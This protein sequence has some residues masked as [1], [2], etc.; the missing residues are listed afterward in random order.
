MFRNFITGINY[1]KLISMQAKQESFAPHAINRKA[2]LKIEN[3]KVTAKVN[4][5]RSLEPARESKHKKKPKVKVLRREN[6]EELL[7]SIGGESK[8]V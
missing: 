2:Q 8:N 7:Y 4:A 6:K 3:K 5:S 1:T